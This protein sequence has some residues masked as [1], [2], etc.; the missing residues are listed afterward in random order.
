MM[1]KLGVIAHA[2]NLHGSLEGT[3]NTSNISTRLLQ[4]KVIGKVLQLILWNNQLQRRTSEYSKIDSTHVIH[5]NKME[6]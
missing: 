5:L 2:G 6:H 3:L 4:K 1:T